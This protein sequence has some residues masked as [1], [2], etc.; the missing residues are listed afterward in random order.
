MEKN[1]GFSLI[2]LMAAA[3]ISSILALTAG[4]MVYYA[5]VG[6]IKNNRSIELQ[7][8][9]TIAMDMFT[10]TIRPR[11]A[12]DI[13]AVGSTLTV[14]DESFYLDENSLM[15][16][17]DTTTPGSDVVIIDDKVD[18]ILF[19]EDAI[20]KLINIQITLSDG[21]AAANINSNIHYR[22]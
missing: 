10:R 19:T 14:G 4:L 2:E 9:A 3:L 5:F 7:R 21:Q 22:R 16:D 13:T 11:E 17:A 1:K 18:S 20:S 6:W 15:H 8:D 12:S